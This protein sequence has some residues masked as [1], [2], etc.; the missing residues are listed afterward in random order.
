MI[1][2]IRA[3][4]MNGVINL[5]ENAGPP[6]RLRIRAPSGAPRAASCCLVDFLTGEI[7]TDKKLSVSAAQIVAGIPESA[8][9]API[10][11]TQAM[12]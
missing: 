3:M 11:P 12:G 7:C 9:T 4:E 1:T 5:T 6:C 10:S 2:F 8:C